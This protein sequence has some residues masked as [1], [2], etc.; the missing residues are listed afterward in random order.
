MNW[1]RIGAVALLLA[2]CATG[3]RGEVEGSGMSREP[4]RTTEQTGVSARPAGPASETPGPRGNVAAPASPQPSSPAR[5]QLRLADA[6]IHYSQDAW[7]HL[8]PDEAIATLRQAGIARAFVS[9]TPDEGTQRLYAR[10]PALVVP[11]LR[12]YRTRDDLGTWTR[13]PTVVAYLERTYREGVHRGIGEFHLGAGEAAL[14]VVRAVVA[15]AAREGLFLHA[16]ADERAVEELA[17]VDPTVTVLWAHAGMSASADSV[18]RILDRYP[19]VWAELALRSDVMPGDR[20]DPEWRELFLRH[21]E[22]IM[23]GTDT[24]VPSR[25]DDVVRGHERTQAWLAQLPVETAR[26]IAN[27]TFERLLAQT[28]LR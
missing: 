28:P 17:R 12:P 4:G 19:N 2:A 25:W 20:L 27:G 10:D 3:G 15:L 1:V 26:R 11:V 23:V 9:S 16:H 18:M 7:S 22:R 21:S 5:P 13:D 6:H 24:W 14:P 8:S